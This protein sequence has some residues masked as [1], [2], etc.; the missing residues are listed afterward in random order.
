MLYYFLKCREKKDSNISKV[1]KTIK[2]KVIMFW[3]YAACDIEKLRFIKEQEASGFL[4]RLRIKSP[5]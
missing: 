3:K 5:F 1:A 2:G 4:S